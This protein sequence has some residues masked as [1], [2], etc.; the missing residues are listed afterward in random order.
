MLDEEKKKEIRDSLLSLADSLNLSELK[1]ICSGEMASG[2]MVIDSIEYEVLG[3]I[4]SGLIALD[5]SCEY[6]N[7]VLTIKMKEKNV[8]ENVVSSEASPRVHLRD[9]DLSGTVISVR[10]AEEN[11]GIFD[12]TYGEFHT[13]LKRIDEL[14]KRLIVHNLSENE[15]DELR[16]LRE[17]I[18][19]MESSLTGR[20]NNVE[21]NED[22]KVIAYIG[23]VW[24]V[25]IQKDIL[26]Q[27][28][29]NEMQID[30]FSRQIDTWK[31]GPGLTDH[32]TRAQQ[33]KVLMN[34][35]NK[36]KTLV[37]LS[38]S[39]KNMLVGKA[40]EKLMVKQND[41]EKTVVENTQISNANSEEVGTYGEEVS[42]NSGVISQKY[43]KD[44]NIY[45]YR[46]DTEIPHSNQS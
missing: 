37:N 10:I 31:T 39:S 16:S 34:A 36:R 29:R 8:Q 15:F 40:G 7:N 5:F 22:G 32:L 35:L 19:K 30:L 44:L 38:E 24:P 26:E 14:R 18:P 25:F 6:S 45:G 42:E 3:R 13:K 23:K 17:E 9:V 46:I 43:N 4:V 41:S 28:N 21:Q 20:I 27:F 12:K 2:S 11:V 33:N 1:K